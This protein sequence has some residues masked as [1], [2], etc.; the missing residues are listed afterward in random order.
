MTK[1]LI[2]TIL[3]SFLLFCVLC[4]SRW[5]VQ[6][7]SLP[8]ARPD[9]F[10]YNPHHSLSWDAILIEAFLDPV[11]PDSRDAWGPL[12]EAVQH[13][14]DRVLLV[15]HLLPLPYHDNAFV[16][17][18]ALHIVNNLNTS[19]TFLLLEQF[20][21]DQERFYNAKTL[22]KSRVAVVKEVVE[23]ASKAVGNSFRSAL[24]SGFNDRQTDL[25][26]RV[27]FKHSCTRGVY[28]TPTFFVNGFTLP[29]IGS[30]VEYNGWRKLIDPLIG[31]KDIKKE[32]HVHLLL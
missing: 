22:N 28:G 32:E 15:V 25:K 11:C 29:D 12:K 31:T 2:R 30:P 10:V 6:A 3:L 14:G 7:Q 18:R 17:S 27:S 20:F 24:E 23:F 5:A 26:T 8:P 19:S 16:T 13:Y 9:G 4:T 21:K 1:I